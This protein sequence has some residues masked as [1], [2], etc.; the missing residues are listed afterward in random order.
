[1]HRNY[2]PFTGTRKKNS[3]LVLC[4]SENNW[5]CVLKFMVHINVMY[6][7]QSNTKELESIIVYERELHNVHFNCVMHF[8]SELHIVN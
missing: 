5:K 7:I 3:A 6:H 2:F 4:I 1:M 8:S